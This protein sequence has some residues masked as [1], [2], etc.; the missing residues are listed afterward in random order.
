MTVGLKRRLADLACRALSAALPTSLRPW[1]EA[2]R[3]ET[4]GIQDDFKALLFAMGGLFGL[5]PRAIATRLVQRLV[6]LAGDADVE[7]A[8]SLHATLALRPRALGVLSVTG[9]VALGLGYM[10]AAGAP[11]RYLAINLGALVGALALLGLFGRRLLSGRGWAEGVIAL[12]AGVLLATA[13][14]GDKAGGASRWVHLGAMAVQ[15]SLILL[16][17]MLVAFARRPGVLAMPGLWIAAVAMALQP[18]RAMA[19]VLA[20]SLAVLAIIRPDR[21]IIATLAVSLVAFAVTLARADNPS[22]A[23]FVDQVLSASFEFH[24]VA[25]L[26]VAAGAALLLA[27]A[28]AGWRR[29]PDSRAAYAVFGAAWL[30]TILAAALGR[31]PTPVVGFGGSAILGYVLSVLALPAAGARSGAA[32][33]AVPVMDEALSE[34][35]LLLEAA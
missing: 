14:A 26:E 11:T 7:G 9:G 23:P 2:I 30:A 4:L 15:P 28:L 3:Y 27:P 16:P 29:D 32:A 19:G 33:Q 35:R 5:L 21:R 34:R 22:P 17:L 13:L 6:W 10:A 20:L 31:Y 18:D 25:G 24:V 8:H 12:M 1:G